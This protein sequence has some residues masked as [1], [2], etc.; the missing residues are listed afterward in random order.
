MKAFWASKKSALSTAP[1]AKKAVAPGVSAITKLN[2]LKKA[3]QGDDK[4]PVATRV[5]VYIQRP[6]STYNDA[7]TGKPATRPEKVIPT[8]FSRDAVV[9]RVFDTSCN[10]LGISKK[11]G[12]GLYLNGHALNPSDRIGALVENGQTLMVK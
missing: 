7:L 12:F 8:F 9:G 10:L 11:A 3:A 2:T 4:I 6:S 1:G 5:Y